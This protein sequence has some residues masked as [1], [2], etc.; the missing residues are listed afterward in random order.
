M[1]KVINLRTARKQKA[2]VKKPVATAGI[3]K[4]ERNRVARLK[5]MAARNLDGHKMDTD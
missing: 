5:S 1:G 2:R 4:P 3:K